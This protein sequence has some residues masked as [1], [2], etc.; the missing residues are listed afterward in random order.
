MIIDDN[1][2]AADMLVSIFELHGHVAMATY[3]GMQ[4]IA[5]ALTFAPEVIFLDLGMPQM[6]GYQVAARLRQTRLPKRPLLIAF[7][8]WNDAASIARVAEAGFDLHLTKT[9]PLD[10]LLGA[11]QTV[12]VQR[13]AAGV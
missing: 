8:A 12:P 4:G 5:A 11:L 3:D 13:A 2:D 10:A 9:S 7:T 6:D 1:R